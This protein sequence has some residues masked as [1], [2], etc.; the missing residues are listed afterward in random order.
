ML[1]LHMPVEVIQFVDKAQSMVGSAVNFAV[2]SKKPLWILP[3]GN[4]L[5]LVPSTFSC[6]SRDEVELA[7]LEACTKTSLTTLWCK[8]QPADTLSTTCL[9]RY[10]KRKLDIDVQVTLSCRGSSTT[11]SWVGPSILVQSKVVKFTA[12]Q[13]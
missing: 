2:G 8:P 1:N 5:V 7:L 10:K 4:R 9:V 3:D 12:P 13:N 6:K 11:Q